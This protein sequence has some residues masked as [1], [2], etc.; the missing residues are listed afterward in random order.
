MSDIFI[1]KKFL[2]LTASAV[3]SVS[4][5]TGCTT[6]GGEYFYGTTS[7]EK[8]NDLQINGFS[9][10]DYMFITS[11]VPHHEQ[12]VYLS[13]LALAQDCTPEVVVLAKKIVDSQNSEINV[14]NGWIESAE[15]KTDE[16]QHGAAMHDG[17]MMEGMLSDAEVSAI[18]S[19]SG[20]EFDK[21][22]LM[23]M[24]SH[25]EGAIMMAENVLD[26]QNDNVKRFA[27]KIIE[28]QSLEIIEMKKI[29]ASL[30]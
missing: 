16:G 27:E 30:N 12:A 28:Q 10:S 21:L 3:V 24:I 17:H 29:L 5:L 14:L 13:N 20:K 9:D 15:R 25:H 23:G 7:V 6:S 26:T 8:V 22:Y 18:G 4:V 1:M 11:M 19:S 2:T